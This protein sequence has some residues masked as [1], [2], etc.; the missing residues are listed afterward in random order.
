MMIKLLYK[1]VSILAGVLGGV[2]AGSIFKRVWKA[3]AGEDEA[4]RA[5]D[6]ARGW[7]EVL[8]AA[9]LQGAIFA[10]VKAAVDRGAAV[11]TRRLTGFWPGEDSAAKAAEAAAKAARADSQGK[12]RGAAKGGRR[13]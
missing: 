4:P 7:R 6:A 1:P 9:T 8:I 11:G 3:A 12:A 5:T 2:L 10:L 13:R